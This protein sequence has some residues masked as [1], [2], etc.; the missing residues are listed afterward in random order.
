MTSA[1]SFGKEARSA[2]ETM[3]SAHEREE[4]GAAR[5]S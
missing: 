5:T 2:A 1:A 4:R 3:A